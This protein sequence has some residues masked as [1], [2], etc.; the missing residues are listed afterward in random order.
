M[1]DSKYK[2]A[3]AAFVVYYV[4]VGLFSGSIS[5]YT[6]LN[7]PSPGETASLVLMLAVLAIYIA[8]LWLARYLLERFT[9]VRI[10]IWSTIWYI[11]GVPILVALVIFLPLGILVALALPFDIFVD[12]SPV[13]SL[14]QYVIGYLIFAATGAWLFVREK[15]SGEEG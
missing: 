4:I 8:S 11:V 12:P 1:L 9:G 7:F 10:S 13:F 3:F 2:Q 14:V 6:L 5:L 15:C